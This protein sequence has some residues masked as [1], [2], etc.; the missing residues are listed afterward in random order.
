MNDK[1][2]N[3]PTDPG[4]ASGFWDRV[5]NRLEILDY[6]HPF[7]VLTVSLLIAILCVWATARYLEFNTSRQDLLSPDLEFQQL[8][9]DYREAFQDFDGMIV[10]VEGDRPESM[11]RFAE[12]LVER[13]HQQ[14]DVFS[15]IYYKVDTEYFRSKSLLFLNEKELADLEEKLES[16][17]DFL[18]GVNRSPGLNT[19][20]TRINREISAG[21]VDTLLTDFL[22]AEEEEKDDTADL[23]LL[24]ALLRQMNSHLTGDSQYRSPW[25]SFLS[26]EEDTLRSEG[27]LVSENGRLLFVLLNPAETEGD[28]TGSKQ[29]IDI[30]R[31]M[32]AEVKQSVPDVQVGLTGGEVIASD[33]MFTTLTDAQR[34]SQLAL[35][36]VAILFVLFYREFTKP[37][38]AV[39]SLVVGLAWSMGYTTLS[40]GHL[41]IMSVIFTTILIGLGIDFGIHILSRY[42]EERQD[43][44]DAFQAMSRTLQ[45]TGRGNLAG[46]ITTAI[47]FGAMAFTPFIGIA[48]LGVIAAGGI[49]LCFLSM[50]LVLPSLITLEE[51]WKRPVY[52][53]HRMADLRDDV[54]EKFYSHYYWIIIVSL[55]LLAVSGWCSQ[56][57]RFDYNLLNMQAHGLEA[58]VY[59]MK[60]IE[61]AKRASWNAALISDSIEEA[62]KKYNQLKTL[63]TVG[64]V[65]SLFEAFPDNQEERMKAIAQLA[66]EIDGYQVRGRD[67]AFSMEAIKKTLSKIRF[68]LRK[69]EKDGKRDDVFEAAQL[70]KSLQ[71]KLET[72]ESKTA[73]QRLSAFSK[74]LFVDYRKKMDNLKRSAHPTP[75][76]MEELPADFKNR[77]V[78]ADGRVSILVYPGVD[79]WQREAMQTFLTEMRRIDPKVT[80]NAV[81]MFE[82]S[83]LMIDGY[84]RGGVYAFIAIFIYLWVSLSSVKTAGLVLVPTVA[85]GVY[86]LGLMELIGVQFNLANLVILP[87]IIGIGVVDGVH[88]V[89]RYRETPE[90]GTNVITKSTGLSVV[91]T[92]ITTIVGFGSLM[93]ADHRGVYSLGLLLSLGVGSCLLTSVTLLPALMKWFHA[94]GWKV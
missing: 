84:L 54:S 38:L 81:H 42:R 15:E 82:S 56:N 36:G 30:I 20:L 19:L 85:G 51:K 18:E 75:V 22:G 45:Q 70:V 47:A 64:K 89:H 63:T 34:A 90:D 57:L 2:P 69:K 24:L 92:S 4:T 25:A 11:K 7:R 12:T 68:K 58:V 79:V 43:G 40:V 91:L 67:E 1:T 83:R 80:G 31:G 62:R 93:V 94:R 77:F 71:T 60:V 39:F 59:E 61:N 46:A 50:V 37:L 35:V 13:L 44:V 66:P 9:K 55:I 73:S 32:I 88:I 87:L 29:S 49:L 16:H 76:T 52:I 86:T 28:F 17:H 33:E 48:E 3:S 8:F 6:H 72:V 74:T 10:V 78:A 65:E 27:Y 21:M 23:S 53:R 41:N 26:D 5:F 14:R